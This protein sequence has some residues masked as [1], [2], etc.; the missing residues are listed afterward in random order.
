MHGRWCGTTSD[1]CAAPDCLFNYGPACDANKTPAGDSTASISRLTLGSVLVGGG[2][3]YPCEKTGTV[4]LTYDDGPSAYTADLLDLL[5]TYN[6][7]A[8]FFITG[9]NN[10][11]GEID[12]TAPFPT[13]IQR[14]H[15]DGHQIAS[16][17]WS[18]ADLSNIT[19]EQRKGEMIKN[20]MA[21]R[22]ILGFIPTYMRPPYSSCT[23]ASGCTTDLADLGYHVIY[24]DLDTSDYLND[25]A[26]LIQN[27]KNIFDNF[28]TG[29]T[30]SDSDALVIG[31]DIHFQTVYNLTEYMLQSLTAKGF[32]LVTVGECLND[33]EANWYRSSSGALSTSSSS[34]TSTIQ[35]APSSTL[36]TSSTTSSKVGAVSAAGSS[37]RA[38][39]SSTTSSSIGV[40]SVAGSSSRAASSSTT[41]AVSTTRAAST[42]SSRSS[43]STTRATS[44]TTSKAASATTSAPASSSSSSS[45][46]KLDLQHFTDFC[47]SSLYPS[48]AFTLVLFLYIFRPLANSLVRSR[49]LRQS[50]ELVQRH[51]WLL[52]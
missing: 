49:N 31:H 40:V 10:G 2:G 45:T 15:T 21:L 1:Y 6:A 16:H 28:W 3:I 37:S 17:T 46:G 35:V 22:N 32:S 43:S 33:P 14:M 5:K 30:A 23:E 48:L 11:K 38:A 20:E 12:T 36:I 18:H 51:I 8:T 42:T 52:K 47:I 24:F 41:R 44:T 27:S 9:N 13:V 50:R 19:S 29:K 39:S 7:K 4:A 26:S 34:S 25:D